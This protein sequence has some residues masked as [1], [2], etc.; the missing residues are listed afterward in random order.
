MPTL[1]WIILAAVFTAILT[2]AGAQAQFKATRRQ[3]ARKLRRAEAEVR[4]NTSEAE[5]ILGSIEL[6]V[7]A[8]NTEGRLVTANR[9]ARILI[10]RPP[11]TFRDFLEAYGQDAAFRSS[12]FLGSPLAVTVYRRENLCLRLQVQT[13]GV[14]A[15]GANRLV[16]IQDFSRQDKEERMRKEFVANVSHELKT[17]LTTIKTYSESLIDWGLAEKSEEAQRKDLQRIYDDSI[18]ME[19]LISDLLLL[20]SLDARGFHTTVEQGDPAWLIRQTCERMQYQAEEKQ[21]ELSCQIMNNIPAVYLDRAALE[22]ILTN[23]VSNALK[24]SPEKSKVA[25]YVGAVR[26]EV[27]FKVKDQGFGI[28][29]EDQAHIFDRFF[30]VDQTGSRQHGGTGLGLSIV[31]ELVELHRARIDLNSVLG[32]GTEFTVMMPTAK[33]VL[34]ETLHALIENEAQQDIITAAAAE[35]LSALARQLGI[36]AKWT[37]MTSSEK[38]ALETIINADS[39]AE[40]LSAQA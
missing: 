32:Q 5:R 6:G 19:K 13:R 1:V 9:A 38:Q 36:V 34:R 40:L 17:P 23:L 16:L 24:Y 2:W 39:E 26:E 31:K 29:A 22:R 33:K 10:P 20:S 3:M 37:S 12:V 8:Y 25:V 21:I 35:D 11:K 7:I 30:R 15:G 18:R 4:V 27:Y 28:P 14:G